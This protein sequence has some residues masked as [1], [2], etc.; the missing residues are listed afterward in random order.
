MG[1]PRRRS[2]GRATLRDHGI[3]LRIG[4]RFE[5][6]GLAVPGSNEWQLSPPNLW[7]VE[8]QLPF[9]PSLLTALWAMRSRSGRRVKY[10]GGDARPWCNGTIDAPIDDGA[11]VLEEDVAVG[12]GAVAPHTGGARADYLLAMGPL[13]FTL[14]L[15]RNGRLEE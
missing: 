12:W 9:D 6:R 4:D 7:L 5:T 2:R 1:Y 3:E 8:M 14:G 10:W 15:S 11:V 13:T